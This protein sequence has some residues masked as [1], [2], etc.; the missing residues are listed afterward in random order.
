MDDTDDIHDNDDVDDVDAVENADDSDEH[1]DD[2]LVAVVASVSSLNFSLVLWTGQMT[3]SSGAL[4]SS[5]VRRWQVWTR[6]SWMC[7]M[8][9]LRGLGSW[10]IGRLEGERTRAMA[11]MSC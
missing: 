4:C 2:G 6:G 1:G 3:T 5:S 7:L 10:D 8:M 9:V 11:C